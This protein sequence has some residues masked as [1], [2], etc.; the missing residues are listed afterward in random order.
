MNELSFVIVTILIMSAWREY[1]FYKKIDELTSKIMAKDYKEYEIYQQSPAKENKET[2]V[3]IKKEIQ[4][5]V[6]GSDF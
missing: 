2:F 4:D 5:P 1:T 6:L 3:K